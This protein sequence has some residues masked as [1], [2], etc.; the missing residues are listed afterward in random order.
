MQQDR[1]EEYLGAIYRLRS[2]AET[3]VPLSRLAEYFGFSPVSVHEMVQKLQASGNVRY[4]PYRGVTLTPSGTDAATRLVRRHRLWERFLTDVLDIPWHEAHEVADKLEHV[5][6]PLVT[7]RLAA[8]LGDPLACPHGAPIPPQDF[9]SSELSLCD[10]PEGARAQITRIAPE[11]PALL[12]RLYQGGVVPGHRVRVLTQSS[13]G[14]EVVVDGV[15]LP[16]QVAA[17][18]AGAVWLEL[19]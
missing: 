19:I 6:T 10:L 4:H 9:S 3:P 1:V 8:F 14:T 17:E 16:V 2:D 11:V 13:A 18:D 7:D 5:A 12:Q 15:P